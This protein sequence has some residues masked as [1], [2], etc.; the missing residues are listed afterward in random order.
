MEERRPSSSRP[1]EPSCCGGSLCLLFVFAVFVV[2]CL[3]FVVCCLLFVV[4]GCVMFLWMWARPW[5]LS[6]CARGSPLVDDAS[7]C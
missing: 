1:P 2:C 4:Y 6:V 3:L 7:D 5:E